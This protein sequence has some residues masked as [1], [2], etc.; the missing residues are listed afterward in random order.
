[1]RNR[2]P[3]PARLMICGFRIQKDA[4]KQLPISWLNTDQKNPH[5]L[6]SRCSQPLAGRNE[7]PFDFY[8]LA[9]PTADSSSRNAVSFSSAR[10][11][12]RFTRRRPPKHSF[13][14]TH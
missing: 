9:V 11:T 6:T 8:V 13:G 2:S 3:F 14:L 5:G 1:M 4:D 7:L 12:K 10:T